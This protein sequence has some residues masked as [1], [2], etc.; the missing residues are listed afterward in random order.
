MIWQQLRTLKSKSKSAVLVAALF[1]CFPATADTISIQSNVAELNISG[2]FIGYD[3]EYLLLESDHGPVSVVYAS[4]S[5]EGDACPEKDGYVPKIRISGE[6]NAAEDLM[7]A[8]V[9]GFAR[10]NQ[11]AVSLNQLDL[12][13]SSLIIYDDDIKV[14]EFSI[15]QSNSLAGFRALAQHETDFVLSNRPSTEDENYY[16]D[17]RGIGRLDGTAQVYLLGF[18]SAVP[19]VSPRRAVDSISVDTLEK[20]LSGEVDNWEFLGADSANIQTYFTSE[21]QQL[22]N[23]GQTYS[24]REIASAVASDHNGIGLASHRHTIP[25]KMLRVVDECGYFVEPDPTNL[26]TRDYPLSKPIYLNVPE[27]RQHPFV[28]NFLS[29]L[30]T[31]SA[32][33]V[34]RR[35]GY[36][37]ASIDP[38]PLNRQGQRITNAIRHIETVEALDRLQGFLDD[39]E[40]MTR[41]SMS[42]RTGENRD[43]LDVS[44]QA[45][46]WAFARELRDDRFKDKSVVLVGFSALQ[47]A[48]EES[49]RLSGFVLDELKN[50]LG[51]NFPMDVEV[52]AKGYG[53]I[54]PLACDH[55]ANGAYLNERV[56]LWVS[57]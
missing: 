2:K 41:H 56:E 8:L 55:T 21:D 25:A 29:W 34:V 48:I 37:D 26:R 32:Q 23:V 52:I 45:D 43:A 5:C 13:Q 30:G 53:E 50:L 27:R 42:F 4:V 38:I 28:Q 20:V 1:F 14:A 44:S 49:E 47:N 7:P 22:E 46:L 6:R 10:T 39:T 12:D 18:D 17:Q 35:S 36:V 40:Q 19:I 33:L 3:G 57:D 54:M 11:Y 51:D 16:N 24:L 15:F 9:E 31:P